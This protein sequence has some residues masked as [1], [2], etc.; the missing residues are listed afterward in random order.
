MDILLSGTNAFCKYL[1]IDPPRIPS[2]DG[3]RIGTQPIQT[4]QDT[5]AW[6]CHAAKRQ[7]SAGEMIDVIV[8][9]A[10]SR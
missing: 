8:V 10:R 5:M 7:S 9:E 3:K 6:Q 1:N 4:T 2:P